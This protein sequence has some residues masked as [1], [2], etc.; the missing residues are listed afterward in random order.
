[1]VQPR[2]LLIHSIAPKHPMWYRWARMGKITHVH[3]IVEEYLK[4]MDGPI[5]GK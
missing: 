4:V 3:K 1:M 2:D 5:D